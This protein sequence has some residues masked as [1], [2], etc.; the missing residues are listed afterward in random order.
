MVTFGSD[1]DQRNL[2]QCFTITW[3][4]WAIKLQD[5]YLF[6]LKCHSYTWYWKTC[7]RNASLPPFKIIFVNLNNVCMQ[8][9]FGE[10]SHTKYFC[11]SNVCVIYCSNLGNLERGCNQHVY[12]DR[13]VRVSEHS[14]TEWEQRTHVQGHSWGLTAPGRAQHHRPKPGCSSREGEN[15]TA[16]SWASNGIYSAAA[17]IPGWASWPSRLYLEDLEHNWPIAGWVWPAQ[18]DT[19]L[20]TRRVRDIDVSELACSWAAWLY[21]ALLLAPS[22]LWAVMLC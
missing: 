22:A 4:T 14:S 9:Q 6:L 5:W 12:R 3:S 13:R 15:I 11:S 1:N 19:Q 21:T 2:S 7:G 8:V 17:V 10:S 16:Q 20:G 18:A